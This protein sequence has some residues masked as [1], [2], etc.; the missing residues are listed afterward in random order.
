[1]VSLKSILMHSFA[2]PLMGQCLCV[3]AMRAHISEY[4]FMMKK[5]KVTRKTIYMYHHENESSTRI[6][7][8][9]E[10]GHILKF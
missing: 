4:V 2:N 3:C 8:V 10:L 5:A 9:L 6:D 7:V 1:V